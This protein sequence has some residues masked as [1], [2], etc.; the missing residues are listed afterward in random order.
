M[1]TGSSAASGSGMHSLTYY[2]SNP[3]LLS[4]SR[5]KSRPPVFVEI[6]PKRKQ[7]VGRPKKVKVP[8]ASKTSIHNS[9]RLVDY[10]SSEE[11]A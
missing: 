8:P 4:A 3:S 2:F 5:E 9:S 1:A 11:L 10:S 6:K 7:P